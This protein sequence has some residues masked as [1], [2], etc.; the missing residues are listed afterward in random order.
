MSNDTKNGLGPIVG[1]ERMLVDGVLRPAR[2]GKVFETIN[3]ATGEVLGVAADG[4]AEDL[5]DAIGAARREFDQTDWSTN[6]ILMLITG[7]PMTLTP[8]VQI[9]TP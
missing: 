1:E 5:D 2:S 4:G 3:P 6:R 8:S 7:Q 9:F